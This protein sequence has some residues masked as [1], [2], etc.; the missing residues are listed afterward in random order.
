[1]ATKA[2]S[3]PLLIDGRV[4]GAGQQGKD[5]W[6]MV[7]SFEEQGLGTTPIGDSTKGGLGWTMDK[8]P[9]SSLAVISQWRSACPSLSMGRLGV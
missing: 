9:S 6:W 1:M 4:L 5:R 2:G 3:T 7:Q 8:R